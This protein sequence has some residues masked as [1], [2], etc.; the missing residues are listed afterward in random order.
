MTSAAIAGLL[1]R[2]PFQ[3]F[4]F[5][6]GDNTEIGVDRPSQVKHEAGN[7]IVT[8]AG[9]EGREWLIESDTLSVQFRGDRFQLT[10]IDW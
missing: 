2:Q 8:V 4:R 7:R 5:V 1:L 9:S 6:L 3:P 10:G